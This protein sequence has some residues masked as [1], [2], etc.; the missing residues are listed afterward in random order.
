MKNNILT[1]LSSTIILFFV[2][3]YILPYNHDKYHACFVEQE[4]Y[5]QEIRS[6]IEKKFIDTPNHAYE[7]I[8]YLDTNKNETELVFTSEYK[9]MYASIGVGDSIIK[10]KGTL[11][12][13]I[14]SKGTNK[15]K[16]Y[17]FYSLCTDHTE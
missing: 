4:V 16:V 2:F 14:K 9:N 8:I 10:L 1:I 13:T 15:S 6:R 17:K 7:K 3:F 12:Y 11:Y 5:V